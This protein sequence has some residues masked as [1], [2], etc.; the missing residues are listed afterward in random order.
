MWR[1]IC[2][3]VSPSRCVSSSR[4]NL[5]R[6]KGDQYLRRPHRD[7]TEVVSLRSGEGHRRRQRCAVFSSRPFQNLA[8]FV[9]MAGLTGKKEGKTRLMNMVMQVTGTTSTF[10][11]E[12]LT[13]SP[14]PQSNLPSLPFRRCRKSCVAPT[15]I[16]HDR[17]F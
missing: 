4:T 5:D 7:A 1:R 11:A 12:F 13:P 3:R 10:L 8:Y 16:L 15:Y 14:A 17:L 9:L 2:Y 6:R